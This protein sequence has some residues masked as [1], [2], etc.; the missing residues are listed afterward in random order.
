M[1][2]RGAPVAVVQEPAAAPLASRPAGPGADRDRP[3]IDFIRHA[4]Q[5]GMDHATIRLLLLSAG[6]KEKEVARVLV[7]EGLDLPVPEPAG[8]GS[9]REA[10]LYLLTFTALYTMVIS[11]V[12]LFFH[13]LDLLFPDPA[14]GEWRYSLESVRSTIRWS[15]ATVFV[16]APLYFGLSR[17]IAGEV[18]RDPARA[19]S[20]VRRWLTYL[21]LFAASVTLM[22]DLITLLYYLLEGALVMRIFLKVLVLCVIVGTVFGYYLLSLRTAGEGTP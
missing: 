18:R 13:Y 11:L 3:V 8:T 5:R 21:T 10:F 12:L 20:A 7:V 19:R 14:W 9:A 4:R 17:V 6:W 22:F 2:K 15:L 1:Q 16:S